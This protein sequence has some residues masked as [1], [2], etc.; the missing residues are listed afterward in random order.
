M[1]QMPVCLLGG[2][3]TLIPMPA[4][5]ASR[6]APGLPGGRRANWAVVNSG[7]ASIGTDDIS[8]LIISPGFQLPQRISGG[9]NPTTGTTD[10]DEDEGLSLNNWSSVNTCRPSA[11]A[12]VGVARPNRSQSPE[13]VLGRPPRNRLRRR[14]RVVGGG[15]CKPGPSSYGIFPAFASIRPNQSSDPSPRRLGRYEKL[16]WEE[17]EEEEEEEEVDEMF[18]AEENSKSGWRVTTFAFA[19]ES[20]KDSLPVGLST[21]IVD[22]LGDKEEPSLTLDFGTDLEVMNSFEAEQT[23]SGSFLLV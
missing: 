15:D 7:I 12:D 17:E 19:I 23:I 20:D 4:S 21:G 13:E 9:A 11:R 3:T 18:M 22:L 8:A 5:A 14:P 6:D 16:G 1:S 10:D 2:L